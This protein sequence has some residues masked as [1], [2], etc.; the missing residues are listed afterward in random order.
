MPIRLTRLHWLGIFLL[1]G[2]QHSTP[3][4]SL[5]VQPGANDTVV[6]RT[7]AK[8]A[9]ALHTL[10]GRCDLTLTRPDG[11]SVHLDAVLD[12]APPDRVRLR[13]WK[14]GQA[15][16]DL[17]LLP[18][19]LWVENN[20]DDTHAP[21]TAQTAQ[22]IRQVIWFTGGFFAPPPPSI[23]SSNSTLLVVR[24]D[25]SRGATV[26]SDID[27][28]T[29]T[30]ERYVLLDAQGRQ[31]FIMTLSQYRDYGGVVWPTRLAAS[32]SDGSRIDVIMQDVQ[33]NQPLPA[34]AFVPPRRAEKAQ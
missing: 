24:R 12:L 23:V 31:R 7:L 9:N 1:A 2:C 15:V 6:L 16:F 29:A 18:G 32:S 19:G 17:T 8:R 4:A 5:P 11:Q 25:A 3:S 30:A 21:L 27:R 22:W 34:A 20:S 33:V 14:L 10:S 28:A 26:Q 13:A